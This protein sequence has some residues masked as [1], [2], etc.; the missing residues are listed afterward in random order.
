MLLGRCQL[1]QYESIVNGFSCLTRT[2]TL[3][4]YSKLLG[5]FMTLKQSHRENRHCVKRELT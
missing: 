2:R 3:L 4:M 5:T 1:K